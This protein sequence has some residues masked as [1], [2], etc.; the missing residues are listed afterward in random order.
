MVKTARLD[1]EQFA[2]LPPE[3]KQALQ[4]QMG[5]GMKKH[6]RQTAEKKAVDP[7]AL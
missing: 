7:T 6:A 2:A 5:G 1:E 4:Y 3:K